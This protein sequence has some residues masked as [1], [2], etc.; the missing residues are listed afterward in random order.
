MS[1]TG[2]GLPFENPGTDPA[3]SCIVEAEVRLV[4]FSRP[5]LMGSHLP[6]HPSAAHNLPNAS[7]SDASAH[8]TPS[9]PPP[10]LNS[11]P[12]CVE[13]TSPAADRRVLG[14]ELLPPQLQQL[15]HGVPLRLV[16]LQP[17]GPMTTRDHQVVPLVLQQHTAAA[18]QRAENTARFAVA[19]AGLHTAEVGAPSCVGKQLS[20][21]PA[22]QR[23]Q[24]SCRLLMASEPP[25]FLGTMWSTARARWCSCAPQHSQR[26]R[27]HR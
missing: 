18:L 17:V 5:V 25:W 4:L 10:R 11:A 14:T 22:L 26:P 12:S 24:R 20:R 15:H 2:I 3:S 13:Q 27:A 9:A 6:P 21:L 1:F 19:V 23:K 7:E 16:Q 8:E